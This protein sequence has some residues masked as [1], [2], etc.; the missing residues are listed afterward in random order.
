MVERMRP[1]ARLNPYESNTFEFQL[2]EAWNRDFFHQP[3]HAQLL[4]IERQLRE[5]VY[6]MAILVQQI[7]DSETQRELT[8]L[9][10]TVEARAEDLS[11]IAEHQY[12]ALVSK[13]S[14]QESGAKRKG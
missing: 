5:H 1:M 12:L 3:V 7:G 14:S 9:V 10:L 11:E 2:W 4:E 6:A 8:R 13:I